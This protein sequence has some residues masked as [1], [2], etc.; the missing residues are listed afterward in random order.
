[1][2][3]ACAMNPP[4]PLA[5]PAWDTIPAGVLDAL[6]TRL[7]MDAIATG[8][9]LAIVTTSR[10]LGTSEAISALA[11]AGRGRTKYSR[12]A[13]S[14]EEA[15]R[16]IPVTT[17]GSSCAWRP[18]P[19]TQLDRVRDEMLLELSAPLVHP[20]LPRQAGLFA[21]A[22]VDGQGPSWYWVTLAPHG[23]AWSVVSV[24]VLVQ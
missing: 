6:C 18:V 3:V 16:S 9:P 15:N 5:A 13:A 8:A 21:R 17:A 24:T 7:T 23:D 4:P 20:F 11:R 1:M 2:L 14:M 19:E 10:P 12:V 22:A